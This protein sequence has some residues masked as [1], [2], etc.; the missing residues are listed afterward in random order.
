M[1]YT[2]E[3]LQNLYSLSV[4]DVN[5][6]LSACGLS[7]DCK[8]YADEEIQSSFDTVRQYFTSER[9]SDYQQAT[10]LFQQELEVKEQPE[11][12]P[13]P[14]G[15]KYKNEKN[16]PAA[17]PLDISALLSRAKERVG[18]KISLGESLS[19]LQACGLQD[20]DEYNQAECDRFLEACDLIKNQHKSFEEVAQH[21]GLNNSTPDIDTD[22]LL[23]QLGDTTALL[24]E[25]ERE[26]IREMVR[27]KAKG[28]MAGLPKLYL[29]SLLEEMKSPAFQQEWQ[30]LREAFRAKVMG[31]KPIS[32]VFQPQPPLMSLPP[33]L[34]NGSRS[35]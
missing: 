13:K 6:T 7:T 29:Q 31:K 12:S 3:A 15:K 5:A 34:E 22:E 10:D 2:K 4:E 21:F 24:G 17:E 20:Q 32:P 23:Q 1:P 19:I 27:Q 16:E 25:E 28:D 11:T 33:T 14:R 26:L 30:Q 8:E 18:A 9:V 35:E